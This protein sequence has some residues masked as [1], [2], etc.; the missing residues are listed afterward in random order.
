MQN[1][2]GYVLAFDIGE[3]RIGVAVA[4]T[5]AR[6]AQPLTV[7]KNDEHVWANI[8]RIITQEKAG[9]LVV[10]LPR[11][12]QGE[13]T[14]QTRYVRDFAARMSVETGL[15]TVL[16]DEALTSRQ[17]ETELRA[18]GKKYDKGEVDTLAAVYIL[19]DYLKGLDTIG[20]MEPT[21]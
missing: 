3:K 13:D 9:L 17:A 7:V 12:L 2:T 6:L 14:D 4:S 10:G 15:D 8:Y 21:R 1:N 16:Q 11:S 19:D 20:S 5:F 18:R